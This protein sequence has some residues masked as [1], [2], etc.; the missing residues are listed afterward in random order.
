M[1]G[2]KSIYAT[3]LRIDWW[4]YEIFKLDYEGNLLWSKVMG[5]GD[6]NNLRH[7]RSATTPDIAVDPDDGSVY[8]AP[9]YHNTIGEYSISGT[10]YNIK[11][12]ADGSS[13][14]WGCRASL[15]EHE[16][17]GG[18]V[19]FD[20]VTTLLYFVTRKKSS[21]T[22]TNVV[23]RKAHR[24]DNA[25]VFYKGYQEG[26]AY[27]SYLYDHPLPCTLNSEESLFCL[28]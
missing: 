22:M 17:D 2:Q 1:G 8:V 26:L 16:Y 3:G 6:G 10:A 25:E 14:A 20:H 12:L 27:E 24:R 5:I 23:V 15:V 13:I 9:T 28:H 4:R 18:D 11:V 19:I 7:M 21:G